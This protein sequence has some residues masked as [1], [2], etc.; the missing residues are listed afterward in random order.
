MNIL[1]QIIENKKKEIILS[2]ALI[3]ENQLKDSEFFDRKCHSFANAIT[4]G[5]GLIAE[6]KRKSPSKGLINGSVNVQSVVKGYETAGA[7][8]ISVL[9]DTKYFGGTFNDIVLARK[10]VNIPIL[11]KDFIVDSYQLLEAKALGADVILL[12]ASGL[13]TTSCAELASHAKDL[14]LNVFLE[15]HDESELKYIDKNIDVIGINNRNLKTF[16]VDIENSIRLAKQLPKEMVK[17]AESGISNAEVVNRMKNEGFEGFLIGEN[18]MKTDNPGESCSQFIETS[19]LS[20]KKQ[21]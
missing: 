18:F 19:S 14:G 5:S 13:S 20:V 12:I 6:F 1:D 15:L 7:S 10:T 16:E 8:A 21:N 4:T 11:R 2:K 17:V 9:T 3:S